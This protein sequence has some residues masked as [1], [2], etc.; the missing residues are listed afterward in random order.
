MM[1]PAL[2]KPGGTYTARATD[3]QVLVRDVSIDRSVG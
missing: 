2:I 3:Y 1:L